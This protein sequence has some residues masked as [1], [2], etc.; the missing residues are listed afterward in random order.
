[1]IQPYNHHL[2]EE[3][4]HSPHSR[5]FP[6]VSLQPIS[7]SPASIITP[8]PQ[9]NYCSDFYYWTSDLLFLELQMYVSGFFP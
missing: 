3:I 4:E 9:D 5:E 6:Q 2:K 7:I 8:P 1:M